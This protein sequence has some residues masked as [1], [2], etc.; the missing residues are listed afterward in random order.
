MV[1]SKETI[2]KV[3]EQANI[4]EIIQSYLPNLKQ[5]GKDFKTVCPF[6]S[7]KTPSFYV[8]PQKKIFHCFGCHVGGD[9]FTFVM[10]H[11]N[12]SLPEA[13]KKIAVRVGV[14]IQESEINTYENSERKLLIEILDRAAE[15]YHKQ[16]LNQS[17]AKPA[18]EYLA[19]RGVTPET[20]DKY[21]LGYAPG[22]DKLLEIAEKKYPLNQLLKTGLISIS[23]KTNAARDHLRNR[24]VFPIFNLQGNAIAFGGR[25][26]PGNDSL[27]PPYLNTPETMV[28]SKSRS[29]YGLYQAGNSI[30]Q[31][32]KVIVLE[33]YMDVLLTHQEG[34]GNTVAPLGTALTA[35]QLKLLKRYTE[36]VIILFDP[37]N[38][39]K[40]SADRATELAFE[41]NMG[42]YVG[43]LPAG[44]DPDEFVLQP[45]GKEQLLDL[46]NNKVVNPVEFK[47][48]TSGHDLAKPEQ[49]RK[50]VQEVLLLIAH[51]KDTILRHELA[52]F[53]AGKL[54]VKEDILVTEL[55]KLIKP[56]KK[57]DKPD[58]KNPMK[59]YSAEEEVV[60]LL[61]Q[62]PDLVKEIELKHF[63]DE[64]CV[65]VITQ[66][67]KTG[68]DEP[69]P[70][71]LDRLDPDIGVWLTGLIFEQHIT[72]PDNETPGKVM[73]D[74]MK[75]IKLRRQE[76]KRRQLEIEIIPML[77][78]DRPVDYKKLAE[79][80]ELT[81][82]LKGTQPIKR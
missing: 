34:V 28:Y 42:C 32:D 72:V 24:I 21:K 27:Q 13:I 2:E 37:D 55:N 18:L 8:S 52:R 35:D 79:F 59:V 6:H 73:N 49:K 30:K 62:Y 61:I 14:Q 25:I 19:K 10:K 78:G 81:K 57:D 20:I 60:C 70:S 77:E 43:S 54:M 23:T 5:V 17:Y 82:S 51:V 22:G 44:V 26:L 50:L 71:M 56:G 31:A 53:A 74:L 65:H 45:G 46:V 67:K 41:E 36:T 29:L 3:R 75:D 15:F 4:V 1:I 7:E 80:Q 64:R 12:I 68:G 38:A 76:E 39:G 66:L 58:Q 16:L 48:S 47:I 33:G 69:V 63:T 40:K 9:V 11:E